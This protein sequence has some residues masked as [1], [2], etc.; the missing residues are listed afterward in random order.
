M[1]YTESIVERCTHCVLPKS[2][3]IEFDPD[4]ACSLCAASARGGHAGPER[5][6][7]EGDLERLLEDVRE[8]GKGRPYD[9]LVGVSGGRDSSYLLWILATQHKLRCLAV[10][11]RTP[12]TPD[13]IDANVRRLVAKTGVPLVEIQL[14][15]EY[16][17]RVAAE[18]FRLWARRPETAI[19]NLTCAPCKMVNR[20]MFKIARKQGVRTIIYGGNKY[21]EFQLGAAQVRYGTSDTGAAAVR[22][23]SFGSQFRKTLTLG[24]RGLDLLRK[25]ASVWKYLPVGVK[26]AVL[27]IN[28]HSVY[29]KL[30]YRDIRAIDYFFHTDFD[31]AGVNA[32]LPQIGWEL[33]PGAN[34]IWRSDCC[35]AEVKNF[36]FHKMT[37]IRYMDT[38]LS[39][40][41]RDG[42]LTREEALERLGREGQPSIAR[43]EDAARILDV[44]REMLGLK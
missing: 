35:F 9:C 16:H 28:P 6:R 25:S 26:A 14:S 21:E 13:T 8:R 4:G 10:Y 37:G 19:A 41:V 36:M 2:E 32:A 11:Y 43:L 24:R 5:P 31:E 7:P 23:E 20:E 1:G 27:Y 34:A 3:F 39:N 38:Y 12:F 40:M 33:P 30:R 44:P 22:M 18:V 42:V 17:R 29:F 15:Q